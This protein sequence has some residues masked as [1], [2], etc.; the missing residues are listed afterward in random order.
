MLAAENMKIILHT[1]TVGLQGA[2]PLSSTKTELSQHLAFVLAEEI[3]SGWVWQK[4]IRPASDPVLQPYLTGT[5]CW[6]PAC[7]ES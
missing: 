3:H 5:T 1:L 4:K 2:A 7:E 6:C